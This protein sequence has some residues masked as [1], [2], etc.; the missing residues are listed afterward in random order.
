M[1]LSLACDMSF[2]TEKTEK[3]AYIFCNANKNTS[4]IYLDFH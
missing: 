3:T 1:Y 2:L 4:Y